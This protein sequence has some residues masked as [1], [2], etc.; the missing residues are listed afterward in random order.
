ML[1]TQTFNGTL[2]PKGMVPNPQLPIENIL[3]GGTTS[4]GSTY[5][6]AGTLNTANGK[7]F[8]YG[9]ESYFFTGR[10]VVFIPCTS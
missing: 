5:A 4:V 9:I 2:L 10:R 6:A 1:F 3:R 7:L 8:L